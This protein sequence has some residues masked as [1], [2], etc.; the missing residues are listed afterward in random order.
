M[1]TQSK[2]QSQ[3]MTRDLSGSAVE[4]MDRLGIRF[5][6][7]LEIQWEIAERTAL[8]QTPDELFGDSGP[9]GLRNH[10]N[11]PF[12]V[13]RVRWLPSSMPDGPGFYALVN[14]VTPDDQRSLVFTTG[15]LSVMIQLARAQQEGWFDKPVMAKESDQPT[16]DGYRPYRLAFA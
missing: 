14:A 3:A 4:M 16:A 2:D 7:P 10:M 6:D 9:L 15:A 12:L 13:K 1:G 5:S 11:E 8:A